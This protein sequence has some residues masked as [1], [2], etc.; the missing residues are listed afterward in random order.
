MNAVA[1]IYRALKAKPNVISEK[2]FVDARQNVTIEYVFQDAR[3]PR[4]ETD[5][6]VSGPDGTGTVQYV[7]DFMKRGDPLVDMT[8][9]LKA[10]CRANG[11][12]DD[13]V[14]I[15]GPQTQPR[16]WRVDMSKY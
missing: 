13:Q 14:V 10:N 6:N 8:I 5:I 3:G 9:E 7:G 12:W 2:V 15:T 4:V 16:T 1:C 11:G